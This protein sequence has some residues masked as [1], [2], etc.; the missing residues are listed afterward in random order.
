MKL[1]QQLWMI[2]LLEELVEA[3]M[4]IHEIEGLDYGETK[5]LLE[6]Q[7]LELDYPKYG[8]SPDLLNLEYK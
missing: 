2:R 8:K 1:F 6:N 7:K 4:T 5:I 3:V